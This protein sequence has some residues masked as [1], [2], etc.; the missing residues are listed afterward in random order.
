[1]SDSA[2]LMCVIGCFNG[3]FTGLDY[4]VG[5]FVYQCMEAELCLVLQ[6]DHGSSCNGFLWGVFFDG[7]QLMGVFWWNATVLVR[8]ATGFWWFAAR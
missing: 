7:M 1:M 6:V 4:Y 8:T 2:A 3:G 5:G